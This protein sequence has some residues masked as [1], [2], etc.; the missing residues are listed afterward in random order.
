MV[1]NMLLY[2]LLATGLQAQI[3]KQLPTMSVV[4]EAVQLENEITS[5]RDFNGS[6]AFCVKVIT[7]L[8][9]V[10]FQSNNGVVKIES[11]PGV[12]LVYLSRN[13]RVL[14][15]YQERHT[16][17][18]VVLSEVGINAKSQTTWELGIT[19]SWEQGLITEKGSVMLI[20]DPLGAT[21]SI[22]GL[23]DFKQTTPHK[24]EKYLAQS[25]RVR[26]EMPWYDDVDTVLVVQEGENEN[27]IVKMAT[28]NG[29]VAI[30]TDPSGCRLLLDNR[31]LGLSPLLLNKPSERLPPGSHLL[32]INFD[33]FHRTIN[34]EIEIFQD[35]VVTYRFTLE[36]TSGYLAINTDVEP[37]KVIV[38]GIRREEFRAVMSDDR[39]RLAKGLYDIRITKDSEDAIYYD[40]LRTRVSIK[41]GEETSLNVQLPDRSAYILIPEDSPEYT[42]DISG[43]TYEPVLSGDRIRLRSGLHQLSIRKFGVHQ[44]AYSIEST[45]INL[46]TGEYLTLPVAP[47]F[48]SGI[49]YAE[50]NDADATLHLKD[51]ETDNEFEV[52]GLMAKWTLPIGKYSVWAEHPE[53]MT[54]PAENILVMADSNY[55][56]EFNFSTSDRIAYLAPRYNALHGRDIG[57]RKYLKI[58]ASYFWGGLCD[59]ESSFNKEEN[60]EGD[61]P[62]IM[63]WE[64]RNL[65]IRTVNIGGPKIPS[66]ST[67]DDSRQYGIMALPDGYG[68]HTKATLLSAEIHNY[69]TGLFR[70]LDVLGDFQFYSSNSDSGTIRTLRS[71]LLSIGIGYQKADFLGTHRFRSY[72]KVGYWLNSQGGKPI[73]SVA[74]VAY[75]YAEKVELGDSTMTSSL[76]S[77][78]KWIRC[79]AEYLYTPK[80]SNRI[81]FSVGFGV[82][83]NLD[84]QEFY[85]YRAKDVTEFEE[86]GFSSLPEPVSDVDL[87]VPWMMREYIPFL[88]VGLIFNRHSAN[89]E[90]WLSAPQ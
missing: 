84:P 11:L 79:G 54:P 44:D 65:L 1:L 21:M 6:F 32:R 43:K 38:Q 70:L 33:T 76:N 80:R 90:R 31:D 58:Y 52:K 27:F 71:N 20:S 48:S 7:P 64:L 89:W 14:E 62:W 86:S 85:W 47:S 88:Q 83:V 56:F 68:I 78:S 23:P 22:D 53:M 50:T 18:R 5:A 8:S 30:F 82:D 49:I 36:D 9:G 40:T 39:I 81:T 15:V 35:S 42:M 63:F 41:Q 87:A 60:G 61:N 66:L 69:E 16:P 37:L 4:R 51:L 25:Y 28:S 3:T 46:S 19:G 24:L 26:F 67:L 59:P 13:E 74:D 75:L 57:N 12:Y 34:Q 2:T 55:T 72:A 17:L 77:L 29:G 45:R 10:T 73:Y